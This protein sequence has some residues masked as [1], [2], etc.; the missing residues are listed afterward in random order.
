MIFSSTNA[1][2]W[3]AR[4]WLRKTPTKRY[5]SQ[6]YSVMDLCRASSRRRY[7]PLLQSRVFP[8]HI[9]DFQVDPLEIKQV[10]VTHLGDALGERHQDLFLAEISE[11]DRSRDEDAPVVDV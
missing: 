10:S 5:V 8:L 6:R 11:A 9:Q 2:T 3:K 1:L 4:C 7:C